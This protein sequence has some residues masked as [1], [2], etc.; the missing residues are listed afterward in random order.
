[1]NEMINNKSTETINFALREHQVTVEDWDFTSLTADLHLWAKRMVFDFKFEIGVP[2]L[3]I[4]PLRRSAGH[5]RKG[6]DGFGLMDEVAIDDGHVRNSQYCKINFISS[7]SASRI[8]SHH[9]SAYLSTKYLA[10]NL[11]RRHKNG[12]YKFTIA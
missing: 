8:D 3:S 5:Y 9:N 2:A 10:H 7:V 4:E 11:L 12:S 1:M 6:R